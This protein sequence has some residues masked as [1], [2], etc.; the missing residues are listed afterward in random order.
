MVVEKYEDPIRTE[1][2]PIDSETHWTVV[3]QPN[4]E[5]GEVKQRMYLRFREGAVYGI[6]FEDVRKLCK[7]SGKY[8]LNKGANQIALAMTCRFSNERDTVMFHGW[9][10]G[11]GL[12]G[13]CYVREGNQFSIFSSVPGVRTS[14]LA[15]TKHKASFLMLK[16]SGMGDP[17]LRARL[18]TRR[19]HKWAGHL[20]PDASVPLPGSPMRSPV[21]ARNPSTSSGSADTY[22]HVEGAN[23]GARTGTSR[24]SASS[25]RTPRRG[26][27][28]VGG[29]RK[30]VLGFFSSLGRKKP[31]MH[32]PAGTPTSTRSS[33]S[34]ELPPWVRQ[35]PPLTPVGGDRP[36]Y[37]SS[38]SR[39]PLPPID[40][41]NYL[42]TEGVPGSKDEDMSFAG[43]PGLLDKG[44]GFRYE[45]IDA[46]GSCGIVRRRRPRYV[47]VACALVCAVVAA[48]GFAATRGD[49]V[50]ATPVKEEPAA[51]DGSPA[52]LATGVGV[53]SP[54][55]TGRMELPSPT[56]ATVA[57]GSLQV[58]V[59]NHYQ[60]GENATTDLSSYPWEHVAEPYRPTKL[61]LTRV[62]HEVE[63][64]ANIIWTMEDNKM[65]EGEAKMLVN[66]MSFTTPGQYKCTVL[67]QNPPKT[68]KA[69]PVPAA[70]GAADAVSEDKHGLPPG[71]DARRG[72]ATRRA[73]TETLDDEEDGSVGDVFEYEFVVTVKYV[74][75]ELRALTDR[76]RET[77]F[78]AV[79]ILQRVPSAVGR[80]V[81]G[82]KY[83]SKDYFNRMHLYYGGAR[84][85]DHWHAG[86]G[87]VTSHIAITMM[88]E[89]AL[90][91]INP[92]IAMPYWDVTIEGTFYDW[93]DFRTSSV[94]SDDW[95]GA[96]APMNPQKTPDRGRFA[97]VPVMANATEYSQFYNPY[98]LLR[99]AWNT[100]RNPFLTRHDHL[101]GFVN[102]KKPSGCRRFRDA[103]IAENWMALTEAFN[104]GAH[105]NIHGLLGG[106]WSPEADVYA[107]ETPY[108]V[109]PFVH[110]TYISQK[111]MWRTSA[112]EC[113]L[114]CSMDQGW[115]D[116]QCYCNPDL[117][118]NRTAAEFLELGDVIS[119]G[120]F[121][122]A[123]YN[124]VRKLADED[125]KPYENIPS[126]STP[127]ASYTNAETR[128]IYESLRD[129]LCIPTMV[130][131]HF[132]ATSTNDGE[133]RV[134]FWVLHPAFDRLW[135]LARMEQKPIFNETWISDSTCIGHNEDDVQ[136][137]HDLFLEEQ[138]AGREEEVSSGVPVMKNYYTNG[139]LYDL[140]HPS[141]MNLPYVY[142]NFEWPHC[143]EQGV[144]IK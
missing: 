74:R 133:I 129:V 36:V 67:V 113:P 79:S 56:L 88:Y 12:V 92:S 51:D 62:P 90:Q 96:G 107:A 102:N 42:E 105:G 4:G 8:K 10:N 106:T 119:S 131:S 37:S 38:G 2:I 13:N 117:M 144:Y 24:S 95:F 138:V 141:E 20:F 111:I 91:S 41:L 93:S 128:T 52:V 34:H 46:K 47:M 122:D 84:D 77:F 55:E 99:S 27:F 127:G 17:Q 57:R 43:V 130:G 104:G 140:L 19:V 33:P 75:R 120:Y 59:S 82:E 81:Y 32:Q 134:T 118:A 49:R 50:S 137:F 142:D 132:E 3:Y 123:D 1:A 23:T 69:P 76:D 44:N 85:C 60:L 29:G 126:S 26:S 6:G 70:H 53:G 125:G 48:V 135:H 98:G 108:I 80:A 139:E 25:S 15:S 100:D 5:R 121:Y 114:T 94:F 58:R 89:Q 66:T 22:T 30:K 83:Y 65:A 9:G 18:H 110:H 63:D 61:E 97:Y 86:A 71:G 54:K 109:I 64:G 35:A 115:E 28:S 7:I 116:C 124:I 11:T 68:S 112:I 40:V 87:F 31:S 16:M 21:D 143:D 101:L 78:N 39:R 136:P 45:P 103:Y 14:S 72:E 73:K